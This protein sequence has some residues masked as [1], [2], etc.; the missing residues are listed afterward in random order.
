MQNITKQYQGDLQSLYDLLHTKLEE[1]DYCENCIRACM[2]EEVKDTFILVHV[3]NAVSPIKEKLP[4]WKEFVKYC[5]VVFDSKNR[6]T[7]ALLATGFE[8]LEDYV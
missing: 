2:E 5:I 1:P 4:S 3:L 7:K 8:N 6:N